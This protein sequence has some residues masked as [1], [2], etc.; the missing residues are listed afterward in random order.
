MPPANTLSVTNESVEIVVRDTGDGIHPVD[1]AVFK[2]LAQ[3]MK[4]SKAEGLGLGLSI[5]KRIMEAHGGSLRFERTDRPGLTAVLKLPAAGFSSDARS[6]ELQN[7]SKSQ[8]H[9]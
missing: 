4:S 8:T 7:D 2:R 1:E 9:G 6:G 3:P 5:V